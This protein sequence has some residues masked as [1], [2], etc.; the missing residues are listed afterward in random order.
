MFEHCPGDLALPRW[1]LQLFEKS[2]CVADLER[3][4]L[5]DVPSDRGDFQAAGR[6][7]FGVRL[8]LRGVGRGV[9]RQFE[10]SVHD[11]T[12]V[13]GVVI[14]YSSLILLLNLIADII[15]AMLDPR[16]RLA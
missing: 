1:Q 11:F 3:R 8:L 5:G 6:G 16:V 15:Y 2:D 10:V 12:V 14:L 13:M 4:I 7:G 9:A